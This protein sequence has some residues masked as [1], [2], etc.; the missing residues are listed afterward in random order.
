MGDRQHKILLVEPDPDLL[1]ILVAGFTRRLDARIT[2]VDRAGQCL[3]VEMTDPHDLVVTELQLDDGTGLELSEHLN[4][5]SARP[6]ILLAEEADCDSEV[7][8]AAMR[9]GVRDLLFKPFP[10]SQLLGAAKCV[11]EEYHLHRRHLARH[12]RLRELVRSV[13]RERRE[14]NRRTELVCRDLVG[15]HRRLVSRV[16]EFEGKR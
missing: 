13:I 4:S 5:F 2:C 6:I 16:L 11:L 12:Y 8:I 14:L 7:A 10:L 3:D 15:A 9:L 1:E